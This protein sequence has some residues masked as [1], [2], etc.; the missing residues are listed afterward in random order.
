MRW[1]NVGLLAIAAASMLAL[2]I[3]VYQTIESERRQRAQVEQTNDILYELRN[4][5]RAT[6]NAETG[7]RG[8]LITLDRQYLDAYRAGR[9]QIE[10]ALHRLRDLVKGQRYPR[11]AELLNQIEMLARAKFTALQ[12]G[13]ELLQQG[14]LLD[15]RRAI[16]TDDGQEGMERLRHAIREMESNELSRLALAVEDAERTEARVLPMLGLLIALLLI[17]M[18][19][20]VRLVTR[21]ARAEA[22]AAQAAMLAE[23]HDR[24]DLLARELNHRVKNLFSV[25]LAIIQLSARDR[26]ETKEVTDSIAQRI[27]SLLTAHEVTQ[28]EP[29]HRV[30]S[31]SKLIATTLA[32]YRSDRMIAEL[33]GEEISLPDRQVAPLG[34]VLHELTT[35]AV[36]YG[37]WAN[38]GT[39]HV[40]WHCEDDEII[41]T[42]RERGGGSAKPSGTEG[43]G[44][45][46]M[47]S[48]ARQFGGTI[49]R[50]FTDQ[51]VDVTITMPVRD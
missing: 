32:P 11:Q 49:D 35:N 14:R 38:G 17:A 41:L 47:T 4:V 50:Q 15:A 40:A 21:A 39:V 1:L 34:L 29:G 28:G 30:A 5:G 42:W 37:A 6:L 46:L 27:R 19:A 36:K 48:A 16:L 31:L 43:F 7:Q 10:P 8:Y 45:Q 12:K 23:A 2:I 22:E 18:L 51:G 26:P 25:T 3:I 44:S 9:A 13:V 24:A 20:T 33:E